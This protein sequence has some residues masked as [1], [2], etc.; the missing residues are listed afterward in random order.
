MASDGYDVALV[1]RSRDLLEGVAE[2][3][4]ALGVAADVYVAD[5]GIRPQMDAV[6]GAV[7]ARGRPLDALV[8]NAGVAGLT[9]IASPSLTEFERQ[10]EVNLVAPIRLTRALLSAM[11]SPGRVVAIASVLARFG[12]PQVHGYCASKAGLMGFVRSLALDLARAKITVNAV[13]PGW[14]ATDMAEQSIAAQA[15]NMGMTPQEARSQFEANVP[16]GRFLLPEEVAHTVAFLLSEGA[17]GI[18]GQGL[19]VCGGVLA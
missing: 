16:L 3:C 19:A 5:H 10:I 9:P 4:R 2:E 7:L 8:L 17:C 15:A 13:L 18:T 14:V 12:A 11:R 1:A 6:A